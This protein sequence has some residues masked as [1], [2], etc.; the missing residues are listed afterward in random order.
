MCTKAE[1]NVQVGTV[2]PSLPSQP[3]TVCTHYCGR[4]AQRSVAETFLG[5]VLTIGT[6]YGPGVV[7][8]TPGRRLR[9]IMGVQE[10][11]RSIRG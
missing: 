8:N 11:P 3:Q 7:A 4:V 10:C 2:T 1:I 5:T 6:R 9:E